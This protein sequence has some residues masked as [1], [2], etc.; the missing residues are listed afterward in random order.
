MVEEVRDRLYRIEV[1][2][3]NSPLKELNS[4]IIKADDRNLIIDTGFNRSVCFEAMQKGLSALN[5]DLSQTDFM[6][7]HMHADHSGLIS[8]LATKTSTVYFSRIDARVFDKD[9]NWQAM[10][11][12]A[13]IN[14]FPADELM[15]ALY[16]HPGYK[17]SPKTIPDF[18]LIDDGNV[19]EMGNYRLQCILTPGH[20]EGHICLYDEDQKILFSGD[21]IL[22]DITPHIESWAYQINSLQNYMD[23]LDKVYNLPVNIVLPGHRNFFTDLKGRIDELKEHHKLRADEVLDVVGSDTRNAYDIAA[24]MTWDIDCESWA[25]FPVAQ[26]WFATGEAIA[27]LRYLESEGRIKRNTESKIV[28]FYASNN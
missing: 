24:G 16:N 4:Y 6:I 2:L 10:I 7:T 26:K 5:I 17:Y 1:P 22:Y 21:H 12:Y 14:G 9:N 19:I 27:H 15:K 23:S 8:R 28:T 18:Y 11:D 13:V 20:T 25:D 3:P